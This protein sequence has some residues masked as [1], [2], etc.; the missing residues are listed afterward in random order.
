MVV[1]MVVHGSL[2]RKEL[3]EQ[4]WESVS[5]LN[6]QKCGFDSRENRAVRTSPIAKQEIYQVFITLA[7]YNKL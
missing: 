1:F 5:A 2:T 4:E 7:F 6:T 3:P